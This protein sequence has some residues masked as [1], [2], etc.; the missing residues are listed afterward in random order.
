MTDLGET[1][2]AL[3]A[4]GPVPR[5]QFD[6]DTPVSA[7]RRKRPILLWL[8]IAW[9]VLLVVLAITA[10]ILPIENP[11]V[12]AGHGIR[13]PPF[14][15]LAQPLG[16]DNLGRSELS[17][18]IF[19]SRVSLFASVIAA[20]IALVAGLTV[21][22]IACYFRGRVDTVLSI[23]IDAVLSFPGLVLL[24][25][26]TAVLQPSV[27]TLIIGLTVFSWVYFARLAR[28]NTLKVAT[29][30]YVVASRGLGARSI[31]VLWREILPNVTASVITLAGLVIA[32]L[33]LAEASLSFLG[34]G[35]RPPTPSWGNMIADG[36]PQLSNAP[37][38][39]FIPSIV[40]FLAIFAVNYFG[41][42]LR[43]RSDAASRI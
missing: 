20:A 29:S 25:A 16:T 19:G 27:R 28:A 38:L 43:T 15:S 22:I 11:N 37:F 7:Q 2:D 8:S 35:V 42:W 26:L 9:L 14:H 13:T 12:Y 6:G 30:E 32:G 5:E 4:S 34:L 39:V 31:R 36:E 3:L 1:T 33:I 23:I 18:I 21:G 17:R 41:D 10:P 24:L 40:L